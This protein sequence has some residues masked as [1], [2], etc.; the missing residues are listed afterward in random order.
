MAGVWPGKQIGLLGVEWT[1]IVEMK[2]YIC[3]LLFGGL[4]IKRP[5]LGVLS[6]LLLSCLFI[7]FARGYGKAF[8]L[9]SS[10]MAY[11]PFLVCGQLL[12]LVNSNKISITCFFALTTLAVGIAVWG[13]YVFRPQFVDTN[14]SYMVSF[15]YCYA[16][17]VVCML[18]K[19]EISS[20][21][22]LRFLKISV[23]PSTY[24]MVWFA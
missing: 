1:L 11:L 14:N 20:H 18:K 13:V 21:R 4:F 12:F 15:A 7:T 23:T 3:M 5:V 24:T 17:F 19:S 6:I 22:V 8:F 9:F 16:I 2:F 10:A